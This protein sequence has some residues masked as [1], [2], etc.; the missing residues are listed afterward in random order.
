MTN[1]SINITENL[2]PKRTILILASSPA[3]TARLRL[4]REVREIDAG[5]RRA[6]QREQFT[7]E[8]KWATRSDDLRR[9]LLDFNPQIVHFCGH[10]T[11]NQGLVLEND[12]GEAQFLP[13]NAL[14]NLF[15]LFANRGVECVVLNACY[16]EVQAEA[17]SQHISYVMGMSDEISDDAAVKFAVGFYDAVGAGWSYEDAYQLGCNAIALEGISEEQTPVLKKKDQLAIPNSTIQNSIETFFAV[18]HHS[19]ELLTGL[20]SVEDLPEQL[21]HCKIQH[22]EFDQSSF[23][24][25]NICDL[26]SALKQNDKL[27]NKFLKLFKANSKAI[28][29]YYGIVH[30]P[31]QFYVGYAFSTWP[32]V[33]LF[34]L[35]RNTN[36]W[37]QLV[38]SDNPEIG[39]DVIVSRVENSVAVVIRIAISFDILK[40]DVDNVVPHPYEDIL[41]QIGKRRID[42][43]TH[44][45]QV[46]EICQAFRQVLD[47]LHTRVDKSLVVHIFYAGPVSLGFSLGRRI[48][49]TIHHQVIVYNYT[50]HTQPRYA[51]GIKINGNNSPESRVV[52]TTPIISNTQE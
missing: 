44:Y 10:G 34:E 30:I 15:K 29:G 7:L 31:L 38:N 5:L 19:F 6:K 13:T 17:I 23:F 36:C 9:A 33:L 50:A 51:W 4:D 39:L 40:S 8:H 21:R 35:D 2:L 24:T 1:K 43:I 28:I 45:S 26:S 42:T 22:M 49:R 20:I 52:W 14:A 25:N 11:S 12:A 27:I 47:D 46:N 16:A 18:R 41:I 48:S 37:Y 32:K 3:N